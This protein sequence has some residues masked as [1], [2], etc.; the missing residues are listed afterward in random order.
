MC[1]THYSRKRADRLESQT[2]IQVDKTIS[3]R[4]DPPNAEFSPKLF[5]H[6]LEDLELELQGNVGARTV[7]PC[8]SVSGSGKY[9]YFPHSFL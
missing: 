6:I 5:V 2:Q 9:G 4:I 1:I 8:F 7:L 3:V